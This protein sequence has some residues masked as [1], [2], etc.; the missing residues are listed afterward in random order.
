MLSFTTWS[1]WA[2]QDLL[3]N[4]IKSVGSNDTMLVDFPCNAPYSIFAWKNLQTY[5]SSV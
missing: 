2:H 4:Y 5:S 1:G 3:L